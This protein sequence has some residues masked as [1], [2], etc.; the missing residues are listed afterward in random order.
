MRSS[1][2]LTHTSR[3]SDRNCLVEI[4]F[5][6][7]DRSRCVSSLSLPQC[8]MLFLTVPAVLRLSMFSS[9]VLLPLAVTSIHLSVLLH[10]ISRRS[11]LTIMLAE[12]D[13]VLPLTVLP[14]R[15]SAIRVL[16]ENS[17]CE[18]HTY[19]PTHCSARRHELL[20]C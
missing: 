20:E 6:A 14:R 7:F 3:R 15:I 10:R 18:I 19:L 16:N 2:T 13:C 1:D 8:R 9:V 12:F 4:H 5:V 17:G 11:L